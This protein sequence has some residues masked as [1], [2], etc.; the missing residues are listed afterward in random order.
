MDK[1]KE[2]IHGIICFMRQSHRSHHL[3]GG[4]VVGLLCGALGSVA[5]AAALEFKDCQHHRVNWDKGFEL[6]R[7]SWECW[8]WW[9]FGMTEVGG[10][11][12][13][14]LRFWLIGVV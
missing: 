1:I 14:L 11:I 6:K 9:D 13:G 5:V 7:W 3:V 12:G 8:D 2:L 10:L 4:F